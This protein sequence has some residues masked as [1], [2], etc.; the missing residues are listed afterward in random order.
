MN[1]RLTALCA[2][3]T[4]LVAP[5][6]IANADQKPILPTAAPRVVSEK[7]VLGDWQTQGEGWRMVLNADHT[8]AVYFEGVI[9]S[10]PSFTAWKLVGNQVIISDAS[11]FKRDYYEDLGSDFMLIPYK[12]QFVMLSKREL[13]AAEKRGFVACDCLWRSSQKGGKG[14]Y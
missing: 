4:C 3:L 12:N 5:A 8:A 13:L 14:K 2:A 6:C 7:D 10:N 1:I 11:L 9:E